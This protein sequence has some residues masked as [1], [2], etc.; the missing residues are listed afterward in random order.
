MWRRRWTARSAAAPRHERAVTLLEMSGRAGWPDGDAAAPSSPA[1]ASAEPAGPEGSGLGDPAL[2]APEKSGLLALEASGLL[3][4]EESGLL[5]PEESG[6]LARAI[7]P[8]PPDP[9]LALLGQLRRHHAPSAD[10][11]LRVARILMA[12]WAH[13]ADRL[14]DPAILLAGGALHDIGKLFVPA[15]TLGSARALTAPERET[16]RRHPETGAAVLHRLGFPPAVV[17]AARDHHERWAGDGYPS[18]A[19]SSGM[20]VVARAV[21]VADAF[22]AMVEPGRAYRAPLGFAAALAEIAAC[23][24]TQFDPEAAALLLASLDGGAGRRLESCLG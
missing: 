19:P 13:G 17:A 8:A 14:G 21:A 3:A 9:A 22:V 20:D 1:P 6:L 15:V 11:S 7:G 18:G 16:V 5:A 10:H 12:M 23:R 2:L 4:P 24:G